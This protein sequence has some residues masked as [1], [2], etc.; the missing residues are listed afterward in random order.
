MVRTRR[1][2]TRSWHDYP[3]WWTGVWW[4]FIYLRLKRPNPLGPKDNTITSPMRVLTTFISLD[5]TKFLQKILQYQKQALRILEIPEC[6]PAHK[7]KQTYVVHAWYGGVVSHT[8]FFF[9]KGII[10]VYPKIKERKAHF[11]STTTELPAPVVPI[12]L[13]QKHSHI[14]P[15]H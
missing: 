7:E 12:F 2:G 11:N 3:S 8:L 13:F 14:F 9:E 10:L 4:L 1:L 6:E 15:S 5:E